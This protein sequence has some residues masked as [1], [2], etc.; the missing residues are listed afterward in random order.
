MALAGYKAS[1]YVTSTPS[2]ALPANDVLTDAGDHKT[3]NE[4]VAAHVAWDKA[5]AFTVQTSPDGTTWTTQTTGFVINYPIGQV[6]FAVAVS[7]ATPGC[8]ITAGNYYP[9]SFLANAKQVD[10]TPAV[11]VVDVTTFQTP[12]SPWKSK[13][14]LLAGS[15]VKLSKYWVDI[16]LAQLITNT[17]LLIL[18]AYSGQNANQRYAGYVKM[19][20]DAHKFA[21][22]IADTEDLDFEVDGQLFFIAS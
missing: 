20:Q 22:N 13:L 14:G 12:A 16:S 2:V 19:K 11:D 9:F 5:T 1:V 15:T 18:I 7:G 3:F 17:T 8:R 6:V 21:V 10:I 4:A